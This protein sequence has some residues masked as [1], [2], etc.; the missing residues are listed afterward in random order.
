[1]DE[2]THCVVAMQEWDSSWSDP[3]STLEAFGVDAE[4]FHDFVW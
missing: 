4:L 1:M 2:M 3:E